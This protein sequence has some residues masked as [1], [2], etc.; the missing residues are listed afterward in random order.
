M[1]RIVILGGGISGLL[2]AW[3][4]RHHKPVILEASGSVGGNY[5]AGGLKYIRATLLMRAL[6]DVLDMRA[7]IYRP[8]GGIIV[9]GQLRAHPDWIMTIHPYARRDIQMWHW[10]KTRGERESFRDS[11]MND[12]AGEGAALAIRLDHGDLIARLERALTRGGAKIITGAKVGMIKQDYVAWGE[13]FIMKTAPYDRLISTLPLWLIPGLAQDVT[14][15]DIPEV[16]ANKLSVVKFFNVR[17]P[18]P[19]YDYIYTP[20]APIISRISRVDGAGTWQAEAP[21]LHGV[22]EIAKD[23]PLDFSTTASTRVIIPGHLLPIERQPVLPT[24]WLML[25]RYAEWDPRSTV[26]KVLERAAALAFA[27]S[28]I[29][30]GNGR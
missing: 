13:S 24:N 6:V 11:C 20:Q 5:T 29:G 4:F 27:W 30:N 17:E 25:G 3:A 14:P 28:K 10:M 26:E 22:E 16:T 1:A 19:V 8:K 7:E 23:F 12:P 2:G 9:D 15:L 18:T 21:G